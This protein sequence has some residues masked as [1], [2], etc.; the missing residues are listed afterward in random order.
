MSPEQ[1]AILRYGDIIDLK[2]PVS[3]THKPMSMEKRAAQ[4]MPFA[5]LTG[6]GD[7]L[8]QSREANRADAENA[9]IHEEI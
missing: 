7:Y 5:A 3:K 9:V 4:F 8:A 1:E 6:Y 2:R